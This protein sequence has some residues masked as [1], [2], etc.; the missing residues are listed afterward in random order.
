MAP[1]ETRLTKRKVRT[2]GASSPISTERD[3]ERNSMLLEELLGV[4]AVAGPSGLQELSVPLARRGGLGRNVAWLVT[5]REVPDLDT[6]AGP[7]HGVGTATSSVEGDTGRGLVIVDKGTA[8][9][10]ALGRTA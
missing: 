4:A 10:G 2:I 1:L 7:L 8:G 3:I 9:V 6:I 5:P